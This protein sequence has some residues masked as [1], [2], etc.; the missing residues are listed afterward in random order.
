MSREERQPPTC[1]EWSKTYAQDGDCIDADGQDLIIRQQD[2]GGGPFYVIETKRWAFDSV[3]ELAGL[4]REAG[5]PMN[6]EGP[7]EAFMAKLKAG[8]P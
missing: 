2:G 3:A 4:L 8:A 7:N 6:A 1:E 5:V